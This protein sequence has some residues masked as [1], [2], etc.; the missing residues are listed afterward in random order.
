MLLL[1]EQLDSAVTKAHIYFF[2]KSI[3]EIF[4]VQK[5]KKE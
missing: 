1:S 3:L 4:A 2:E 5:H